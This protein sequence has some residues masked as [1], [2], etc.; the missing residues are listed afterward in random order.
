MRCHDVGLCLQDSDGDVDIQRLHMHLQ[1]PVL[2]ARSVRRNICYGLEEEDGVPSSQVPSAADVERAAR[3]ANA[4]DFI[5]AMLQGYDTVRMR[6]A[7]PHPIASPFV[8]STAK[9]LPAL[10]IVLHV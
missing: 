8:L 1:E 9:L 5:E 2:F 6:M 3:L 10:T 4:H 7:A